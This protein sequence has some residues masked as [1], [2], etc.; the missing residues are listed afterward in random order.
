MKNDLVGEGI[1]FCMGKIGRDN[2]CYE[3]CEDIKEAV[4]KFGV[5]KLQKRWGSASGWERAKP[6]LEKIETELNT[7]NCW[8]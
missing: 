1:T 6:V 5:M 7:K 8:I 2:R 3:E 4:K